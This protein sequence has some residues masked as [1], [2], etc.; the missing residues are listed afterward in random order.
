LNRAHKIMGYAH[1]SPCSVMLK[2]M[3]NHSHK[4]SSLL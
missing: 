3:V 1:A 4:L 2:A